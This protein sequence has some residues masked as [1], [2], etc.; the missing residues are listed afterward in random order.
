MRIFEERPKVL[1]RFDISREGSI[2]KLDFY[3]TL[4]VHGDQETDPTDFEYF[5]KV[6]LADRSAI[7]FQDHGDDSEI[8][9]SLSVPIVHGVTYEGG[10]SFLDWFGATSISYDYM[11]TSL[12]KSSTLNGSSQDDIVWG[13]AFSDTI[14]GALGNDFIIGGAGNDLLQGGA[15]EDR[16]FGGVGNDVIKGGDRND[17]LVGD[18]GDDVLQGEG[19]DDVLIGGDGIDTASY[20]GA[21]SGVYVEFDYFP[22]NTPSHGGGQGYDRLE[23]IENIL[24]GNFNDTL[25]GNHANNVLTGGAGD[26]S[27]QGGNGDDTLIGGLGSDTASYPGKTPMISS[28]VT[29]NLSVIGPQQIGQ[30]HGRDTLVSIENLVG[31]NFNDTFIGNGDANRLHGEAGNDRFNGGAGNDTLDGGP[32]A[33]TAG[34]A[35]ATSGIVV[36]LSVNVLQN[37]GGGHDRDLLIDVENVIGGKFND[38]LVGNKAGNSLS[39]GAGNDTLRGG[40][41]ND[42]LNGG[43]GIDTASFAGAFGGVIVNLVFSGPMNIG[44][45][46]DQDTLISIENVVGGKFNDALMGHNGANVLSGEAGNDTLRGGGGNDTLIGGDGRDIFV[47]NVSDGSDTITDW[48]KD[49]DKI[50]ILGG[51]W[52]GEVI[53]NYNDIIVTRSAE[54]T[55]VDFGSTTIKLVGTNGVQQS[56]FVF[57]YL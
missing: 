52:N 51:V 13:S 2:I 25:I 50:W 16:I 45:G 31:G 28:G 37:I 49:V 20:A 5:S 43:D 54:D 44:G 27:L 12:I 22:Y 29:I 34:Y 48:T 4:P 14:F 6:W 21:T 3:Y 26:D 11:F 35:D 47:F 24:G 57:L 55:I 23:A 40:A 30:G 17:R 10:F 42:T 7:Y 56:D 19:G 9:I 38:M 46:H 32:G 8:I 36:N 39:G 18:S 53:E 33:D 15:G 1:P 41:G